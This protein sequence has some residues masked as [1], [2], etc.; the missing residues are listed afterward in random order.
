MTHSVNYYEYIQSAEWRQKAHEAKQRAG[1]RCQVCN[2]P[3]TEVVLDAHH[4]T[5]ERLGNEHPE[6]ITV[7]CRNCHELYE[8]NRKA[9]YTPPSKPLPSGRH[10]NTNIQLRDASHFSLIDSTK[11]DSRIRDTSNPIWPKILKR[12]GQ[13]IT[14]L[15]FAGIFL[16]QCAARDWFVQNPET[17]EYQSVMESILSDLRKHLFSSDPSGETWIEI[18]STPGMIEFMVPAAFRLTE[19]TQDRISFRS[20]ENELLVECIEGLPGFKETDD[21]D[22]N[23]L[24]RFLVGLFPKDAN[25]TLRSASFVNI[26]GTGAFEAEISLRPE[27]QNARALIVNRDFGNNA[28]GCNITLIHRGDQP[29]SDSERQTARRVLSSVVWKDVQDKRTSRSGLIDSSMITA[30]SAIAST[31]PG[32]VGVGQA[33]LDYAWQPHRFENATLQVEFPPGWELGI[34]KIDGVSLV[35]GTKII[36]LTWYHNNASTADMLQVR[37][38][39]PELF[40]STM[41]FKEIRIRESLEALKPQTVDMRML[42]KCDLGGK[43]ALCYVVKVEAATTPRTP[44]EP[45][46]QIWF[47]FDC[48]NNLICDGYYIRF[49]GEAS[50]LAEEWKL[51][52][53]F[54]SSVQLE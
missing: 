35:S 33:E 40:E 17:G 12:V 36:F 43:A 31:S 2:R 22:P 30:A 14:V 7:L 38:D 9:P 42:D 47:E 18:S 25:A 23:T 51:L 45:I 26:Q 15:F 53:R 13:A 46:H 34:D 50:L 6:D 52:G 48:E 49:G 28:G 16:A 37:V 4:R 10:A 11:P 44:T 20:S 1:Y 41:R 32:R 24:G 21:I 27:G 29:I 5:Y 8:H 39:H 54:I 3:A 19:E